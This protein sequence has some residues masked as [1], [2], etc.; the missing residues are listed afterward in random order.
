MAKLGQGS[1]YRTYGLVQ[2]YEVGIG[3]TTMTLTVE[4][5]NETS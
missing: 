2:V 3:V 5:L 1:D 4:K